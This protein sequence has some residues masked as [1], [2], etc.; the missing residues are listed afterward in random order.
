MYLVI[1][2]KDQTGS[3]CYCM[4]DNY[5]CAGLYTTEEKASRRVD[6]LRAK[7]ESVSVL[8]IDADVD[9]H[10]YEGE[11]DSWEFYG[12]REELGLWLGGGSY[13]E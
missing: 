6:E 11:I 12:D 7:K 9:L 3:R 8:K 1:V 10:V 2:Y 4:D 5:Y 13:Y